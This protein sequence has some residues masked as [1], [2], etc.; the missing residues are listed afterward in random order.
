MKE[1]T[2]ASKY[3][4]CLLHTYLQYSRLERKRFYYS[5][6]T[7]HYR[8]HSSFSEPF[9]TSILP[10]TLSHSRPPAADR[11]DNHQLMQLAPGGLCAV[12]YPVSWDPTRKPRG[13]EMSRD[14]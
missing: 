6:P 8:Q 5:T 3:L 10:T 9:H 4:I 12:F 2:P 13:K 11:T 7:C 14:L 1:S